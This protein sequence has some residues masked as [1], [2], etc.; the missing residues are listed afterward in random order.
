[1]PARVLPIDLL[2]FGAPL[3]HNPCDIAFGLPEAKRGVVR[4][5]RRA[6]F[7]L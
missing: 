5:A 7:L 2:L 6:R 4:P 3:G 1:V